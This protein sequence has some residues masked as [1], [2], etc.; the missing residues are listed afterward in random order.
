MRRPVP[1][2]PAAVRPALHAKVT[3]TWPRLGALTGK[4]G[5]RSPAGSPRAAVAAVRQLA[6]PV[7]LLHVEAFPARKVTRP[8]REPGRKTRTEA[9]IFTAGRDSAIHR[10]WFNT[11]VWRPAREKAGLANV[12]EN[13]MHAL[14]HCYDA[15]LLL[16]GGVDIRAL[17]EFLGHH[18]PAFT[19]RIYAHLMP[20]ADERGRRAMEAALAAESDGWTRPRQESARH[21]ARSRACPA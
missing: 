12:C 10:T 3:G 20:G 9:L 7:R 18:D 2:G 19:L 16:A 13:G 21:E 17:S 14:R 8:W 6:P 11:D 5:H 1:H 4:P 15:L